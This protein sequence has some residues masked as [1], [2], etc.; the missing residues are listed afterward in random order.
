MKKQIEPIGYATVD[1]KEFDV[2][3]VTKT[4]NGMPSKRGGGGANGCLCTTEPDEV[5]YQLVALIPVDLKAERE[6]KRKNA[7]LPRHGVL[8]KR[9]NKSH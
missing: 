9:T 5:K 3:H 7:L 6:A 4:K 2:C 1:M 8:R